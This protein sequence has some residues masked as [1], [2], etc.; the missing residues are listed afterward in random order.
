M[1]KTVAKEGVWPIS[2]I[3][4]VFQSQ[5]MPAGT[6]LSFVT[7]GCMRSPSPYALLFSSNLCRSNLTPWSYNVT[8]FKKKK[9]SGQ[10]HTAKIL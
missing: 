5:Q 2:F 8:V 9:T 1:S 4:A 10:Q 3:T 7:D 6:P